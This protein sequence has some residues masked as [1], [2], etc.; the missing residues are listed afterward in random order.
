MLVKAEDA[1]TIFPDH[2][3]AG[4]LAV[5]VCVR[6]LRPKSTTRAAEGFDALLVSALASMTAGEGA[7]KLGLATPEEV[8]S[9]VETCKCQT[10]L[11]LTPLN[12]FRLP[13]R[14]GG[15]WPKVQRRYQENYC[16]LDRNA[17]V[18]HQSSP[19][20][21]QGIL[22]MT[23]TKETATWG[24]GVVGVATRQPRVDKIAV[25]GNTGEAS[26]STGL[27]GK[28]ETGPDGGEFQ[29]M[30]QPRGEG[31]SGREGA[32]GATKDR[33][34]PL[35]GGAEESGGGDQRVAPQMEAG[36]QQEEDKEERKSMV[37][38]G[39]GGDE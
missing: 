2:A 26:V 19:F 5:D 38:C 32:D 7:A 30:Q 13:V 39:R 27:S 37:G 4:I 15:G 9:D 35:G 17:V 25:I 10:L 1:Q 31:R 3:P 33:D 14:E 24:P 18:S 6:T 16:C 21:R 8:A 20:G 11:G 23:S 36:H 34:A 28:R 12:Q 29:G 22:T